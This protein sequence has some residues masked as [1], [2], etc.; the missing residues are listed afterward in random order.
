M[1]VGDKLWQF[2]VNRRQWDSEKRLVW[3]YHWRPMFVIGET[4]VSWL[5]SSSDEPTE[6]S[7]KYATKIPKKL[8]LNPWQWATSEEELERREWIHDNGHRLSDA[9][10]RC[11]DYQK[12]VLIADILGYEAARRRGE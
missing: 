8:A 10:S 11:G 12:L 3:R 7:M 9:V 5:V 4:R 2:D 6:L 1:K